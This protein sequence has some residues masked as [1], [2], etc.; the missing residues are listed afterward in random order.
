MN[1]RLGTMRVSQRGDEGYIHQA[2]P[3]FRL[4]G[5]RERIVDRDPVPA[6]AMP[7]F[8]RDCRLNLDRY[9]SHVSNLVKT[10]AVSNEEFRKCRI[11]VA[12]IGALACLKQPQKFVHLDPIQ[13]IKNRNLQL[14]RFGDTR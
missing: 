5:E 9:G 8:P 2:G 13:F 10:I 6:T 12:H 7:D 1:Q 4:H 3:R 14:P 11:L